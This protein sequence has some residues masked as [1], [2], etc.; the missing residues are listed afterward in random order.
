MVSPRQIFCSCETV[1]C[2]LSDNNGCVYMLR[3]AVCKLEG[4]GDLL[5]LNMSCPEVLDM[6]WAN[7]AEMIRGAA[8]LLAVM[9]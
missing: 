4:L 6:V 9:M 8:L 7:H 2:M 1:D 3:I 5:S